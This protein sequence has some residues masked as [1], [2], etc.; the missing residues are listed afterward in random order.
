MQQSLQAAVA[1]IH[2]HGVSLDP[3][4][5]DR[6]PVGELVHGIQSNVEAGRGVVDG[7]DEDGLAVV[8]ELPASSALW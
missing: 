7:Q 1:D 5:G 8:A 3:T 4:Q 2:L 6:L